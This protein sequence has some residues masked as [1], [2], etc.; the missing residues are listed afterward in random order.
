VTA[1]DR[2]DSLRN[3]KNKKIRYLL[4]H[5]FDNSRNLI[6]EFK[7]DQI[8]YRSTHQAEIVPLEQYQNR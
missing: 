7:Q 2:R 8:Y 1:A 5:I 6:L 3:K 4:I